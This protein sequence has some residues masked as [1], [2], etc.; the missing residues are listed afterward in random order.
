M[1]KEYIVNFYDNNGVCY[2]RKAARHI[3]ITTYQTI[4]D[5]ST[6]GQTENSVFRSFDELQTIQVIKNCFVITFI[7]GQRI[8]I[9]LC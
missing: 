5:F 2:F 8:T 6:D 7:S 9:S 4:I 3:D 1:N